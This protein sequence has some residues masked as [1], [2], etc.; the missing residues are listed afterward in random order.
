MDKEKIIN[1]AEKRLPLASGIFFVLAVIGGLLFLLFRGG[2][3]FEFYP[4]TVIYLILQSIAS[5]S[6]AVL[7]FKKIFKTLSAVPIGAFI[8]GL[9]FAEGYSVVVNL[10]V[11]VF[12]LLEVAYIIIMTTL[13][14]EKAKYNIGV[15]GFI[16]AVTVALF[17]GLATHD[18]ALVIFFSIFFGIALVLFNYN[19]YVLYGKSGKPVKIKTERKEKDMG[20]VVYNIPGARGRHLFVYE[21]KCVI[22][23]KANLGSLITGNVT[24]GEKTIYYADCIGVQFKASGMLLGYLQLETASS[25]MN[26]RMDNFFNENSFTY[27]GKKVSDEKMQEVSDYILKQIERYKKGSNSPII[28]NTS[29][30]DEIKKYKD[31]LDEGIIS[32]EEFDAKKKQLLGL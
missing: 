18:G 20:D 17:S 9:F 11:T 6:F 29:S 19:F 3:Y 1:Q 25:A 14:K 15:L 12:C 26:N 30:A 8:I 24:D 31:L 2:F 28:M 27:D 4:E 23:T 10:L 13:K 22:R 32:Q 16:P 5:I 7:S 21:D